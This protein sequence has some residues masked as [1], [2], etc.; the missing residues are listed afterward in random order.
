[1][2]VSLSGYINSTR[3]IIKVTKHASRVKIN[4][5]CDSAVHQH[6]SHEAINKT[7][8]NHPSTVRSASKHPGSGKSSVMETFYFISAADLPSWVNKF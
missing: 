1:M 7:Q 6:R 3:S 5:I 2:S 8:R 4:R